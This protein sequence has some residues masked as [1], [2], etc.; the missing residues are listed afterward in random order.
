[1]A[2]ATPR[3]PEK[4]P[5]KAPPSSKEEALEVGIEDSFPASDPP[6]VT[7]PHG[8]TST[9]GDP[10]WSSKGKKGRPQKEARKH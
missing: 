6:S 3:K 1:M 7:Q 10:G 5:K 9:L 8:S 2:T 4:Q